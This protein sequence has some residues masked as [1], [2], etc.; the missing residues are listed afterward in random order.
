MS[1]EVTEEDLATIRRVVAELVAEDYDPPPSQVKSKEE[2]AEDRENHFRNTR[3]LLKNYRRIKKEVLN[4]PRIENQLLYDIETEIFGG[5]K[6]IEK[7]LRSKRKS[8]AILE[9]VDQAIE[10]YK[11]LSNETIRFSDEEYKESLTDTF[12]VMHWYYISPYSNER[13]LPTSNPFDFGREKIYRLLDEATKDLSI[14]LFG[15]DSEVFD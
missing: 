12:L 3:H 13:P 1:Y 10:S 2:K 6:D 4:L 5:N 14:V 11:K 15:M 7:M 9:Y 8:A